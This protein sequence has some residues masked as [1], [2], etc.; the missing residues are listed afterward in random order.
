MI[1]I[2]AGI[3]R[4]GTSMMMEALDAGGIPAIH[5][6]EAPQY[7]PDDYP[8]H[9]TH[10]HEGWD[11]TLAKRYGKDKKQ[12][13]QALQGHCIKLP[14]RYVRAHRFPDQETRVVWMDRDSKEIVASRHISGRGAVGTWA[15]RIASF[16]NLRKGI[17]EYLFDQQPAYIKS[18]TCLWYPDVI[19][20]PRR[21]FQKLVDADWPIDLDKAVA[22]V[23]PVWYRQRPG[24]ELV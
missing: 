15:Q 11:H 23:D 10:S 16:D 19:E 3:A 20:N 6:R 24:T 14:N 5:N 12:W 17:R 1:Y 8:F 7:G 18:V 2:V 21:E 13:M 9:K 22:I 4:S